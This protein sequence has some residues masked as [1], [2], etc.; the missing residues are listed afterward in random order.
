ME[1]KS[2]HTKVH[3][4]P[5]FVGCVVGFLNVLLIRLRSLLLAAALCF[6]CTLV[7]VEKKMRRLNHDI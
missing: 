3:S 5:N 2:N 7:S 6:E 1:V 4:L